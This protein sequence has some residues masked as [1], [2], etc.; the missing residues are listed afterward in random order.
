MAFAV[1]VAYNADHEFETTLRG[2]YGGG[3]GFEPGWRP[4]AGTKLHSEVADSAVRRA[5]RGLYQRGLL[6]LAYYGDESRQGNVRQVQHVRLGE[7]FGQTKSVY[8][9]L[10]QTVEHVVELAAAHAGRDIARRRFNAQDPSRRPLEGWQAFIARLR[11]LLRHHRHAVEALAYR[12]AFSPAWA[13]CQVLT[14]QTTAVGDLSWWQ[15]IRGL[16]E[17]RISFPDHI[18]SLPGG[19]DSSALATPEIQRVLSL[20]EDSMQLD[21]SRG[22]VVETPNR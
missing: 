20:F 7:K 18:P 22:R 16:D 21:R 17:A 6:E 12:G 19:W 8:R 4:L 15:V 3:Y 13:A 11:G 5:V 9:A 1:R 14:T 2:A 10:P